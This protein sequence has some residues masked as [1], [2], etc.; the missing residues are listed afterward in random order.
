MELET[1]TCSECPRTF[2]CAPESR[3]VTCSQR[4]KRRR[5]KRVGLELE[6]RRC[7]ICQT[8]FQVRVTS[9]DVTCSKRACVDAWSIV[10]RKRA[11][12]RR[13]H[14]Q[15]EESASRMGGYGLDRDP[16]LFS[17]TTGC[18]GVRTW[19]CPEML[20]FDYHAGAVRLGRR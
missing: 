14:K 1:R 5:E 15:K 4:C 19:L 6:T 17:M 8:D 10:C 9:N 13:K 3:R 20:P 16:F 11:E 2:Q 7:P 12:A 18:A